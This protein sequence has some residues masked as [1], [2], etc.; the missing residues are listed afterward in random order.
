MIKK[1]TIWIWL[2]VILFTLNAF[3]IGTIIYRNQQQSC[4]VKD[5]LTGNGRII[6]NGKFFRKVVGF[7]DA[8]M[9]KFRSEN[10]VF[11]PVL[12]QLTTSIDSLKIEMYSEMQV[13]APDTARLNQLAAQIGTKHGLLKKETAGFYLKLKKICSAEQ[14]K[15]LAYAFEPI[16]KTEPV[17]TLPGKR[18]QN[19]NNS[20]KP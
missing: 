11:R 20:F 16:F 18:T 7:D 13:V 19:N 10:S 5:A 3:T 14:E 9:E 12:A 15:Q 2:A 8:Q 1:S 4:K 6:L 17:N